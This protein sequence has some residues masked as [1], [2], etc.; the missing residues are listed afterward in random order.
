MRRVILIFLGLLLVGCNSSMA[1]A[2]PTPTNLEPFSSSPTITPL[3]SP[4]LSASSTKTPTP[5][6]SMTPTS[7][8]TMTETLVETVTGT[9]TATPV[10]PIHIFPL[11]PASVASF[12][13]GTSS[14]GYPAT[15]IFAPI[16]TKF[17]AVTDGVVD[18][19]SYTDLWDAQTD[20]PALR[21][22]L[23]VAIIGVD[24]RRYYG[25]HLSA[26]APRIA[27]GVRVTTGQLLGLVGNTGDARTT[28]PHLHFGISRP[29]TPDDWK[30]RRGQVDPFPFLQAWK[31][32]I[33][34]TPPLP[35]Q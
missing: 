11:Q 23:S 30:S 7:T 2:N 12:S 35:N 33:D 18:F 15:D 17:V 1:S 14:H 29:T 22:G 32:G 25:S 16:G 9:P 34:I 6:A 28:T 5:T 10:S 8:E 19:V 27:P 13:E 4:S 26:I 21:G 20:D 24:G 31:N 3:P